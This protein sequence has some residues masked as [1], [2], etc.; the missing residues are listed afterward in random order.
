MHFVHLGG[1]VAII[2]LSFNQPL[3]TVYSPLVR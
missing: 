2:A 3:T 1:V